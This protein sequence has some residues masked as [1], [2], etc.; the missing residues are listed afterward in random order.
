MNLW[1]NRRIPSVDFSFISKKFKYEE[2]IIIS[3]GPS[4]D[5]SLAF[6]KKSKGKRG[7]IAVNTVLRRLLQEDIVPDIIAAADQFDELVKHIKGIESSTKDI[8]LIADWLL[9]RNY[10]SLYEGTVCFVRTNASS[11]I[12]QDFLPNEP[13]WD[14]S[15]TVACLAIEAAIHLRAKT[16]YLVGQDLAYPSGRKYA[17]KMPHPEAPEANWE[18]KVPSVDG[19]MVDT[20]EAFDWFRK[21]IEFQISKYNSVSFINLSKHGAKIYGTKSADPSTFQS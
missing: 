7:L 10:L 15:G 1:S 19:S 5:D 20:S 18:I 9:N 4:F 14:I 3:A 21:A 8:I 11:K 2:W 17:K 6:L 13:V 12:T 16:I